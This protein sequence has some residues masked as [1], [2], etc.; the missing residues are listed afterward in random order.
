MNAATKACPFCAEQILDAAIKCKHCGSD[1]RTG[2]VSVAPTKPVTIEQTSKSIKIAKLVGWSMFWI[3]LLVA[4]FGDHS[5]SSI[6]PWIA[7][8]LI[9]FVVGVCATF[10]RWWK[11]G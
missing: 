6:T 8:T 9:G 11:N 7:M 5:P 2:T 4:I 1:I 10:M 3:G